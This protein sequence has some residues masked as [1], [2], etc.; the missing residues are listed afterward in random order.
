MTHCS[1]ETIRFPT[2]RRRHVE[3]RFDGGSLLLRQADRRLGLSAAVASRLEDGRQPG[4][5]RH[6]MVDLVRQRVFAIAL[7]YEDLNDYETLRH[8]PGIQTAVE[9]DQAPA[10]PSSPC[11]FENRATR[12]PEC[13]PHRLHRHNPSHPPALAALQERWHA[14]VQGMK[15]VSH[16]KCPLLSV[17]L[18]CS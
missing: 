8:D 9:R 15:W 7:G 4:K 11:R 17:W 2:C 6:R 12:R 18:G 13:A 1:S 10:S 3:A 5:V 14:A 16:L